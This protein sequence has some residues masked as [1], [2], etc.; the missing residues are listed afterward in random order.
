MGSRSEETDPTGSYDSGHQ[1]EN[2]PDPTT[3]DPSTD[4]T[5]APAEKPKGNLGPST[6][7]DP[8]IGADGSRTAAPDA[9]TEDATDEAGGSGGPS[10][11][12][13]PAMGSSGAPGGG[14]AGNPKPQSESTGEGTGTKYEKSSGL[15]ADGGD[16]DATRPG[17]G[18]EA[19][20]LLEEQ[21]RGHATGGAGG[22]GGAG[23]DAGHPTAHEG[24]GDKIKSKLHMG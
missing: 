16:F 13:T 3:D 22:N 11:G 4:P 5:T 15:Q 10:G 6:T 20:R 23:S 24:V 12:P 19:N 17:A 21:G 8:E 9:P 2:R 1:S 7:E 18:R 14:D